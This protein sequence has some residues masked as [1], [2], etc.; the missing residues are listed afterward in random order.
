[1]RNK[2]IA[3]NAII[4]AIVGL[5]S[6]VLM[7]SAL[8]AAAS[9]TPQLLGD[10]KH[11]AQS[12]SARLQL[13]GLRVERWLTEK[14]AEPH[15]QDALNKAD[16]S[17][18][19]DAATALCD[20]IVAA[21]K[22]TPEFEGAVPSLVILV[23]PDGKILGRNNSTL[24]RKEDLG[25]AYPRFKE[26][27]AAGNSG[28]DVWVN[29]V[30]QDQYL[31]SYAPVRNDKGQI[32]GAI[33]AG[34][35][36]NDEL[37]RVADATTGRPM[38]IAGPSADGVQILAR[39]AANTG[40]LDTAVTGEGKTTVKS[41]LD[42][43]HSGASPVGDILIAAAP[44]EGFG[45]G[46]GSV[47]VV[48][49][50]ATIIENAGAIAM[51]LLGVTA[52]GIVLVLIGGWLLGNYIS[53]PIGELEEGL[54]AILNGQSDKRFNLDH[55]ELGGLAFRIDQ[56]LNQLMGVEEDTTDA[57]GRVSRTPSPAALGDDMSEEKRPAADPAAAQQLAAE[58]AA[59]YYA[60]LYREYVAAKKGIGEATDHITEQ[61]FT[62]RIQSMEQ[63]AQ[64]KQG[65]QVRYQV[66][67][68]G[69]EVILLPVPLG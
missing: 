2:I 67:A 54:L 24:L 58:P 43:N 39:S 65:R 46:K 13:D 37:S 44:L 26:A 8:V 7:R 34:F 25:A 53:G 50:P 20:S 42:T 11:N 22:T 63:E 10:A 14:A 28:S 23:G 64:Q 51:P 61:T 48:S 19:G 36:I 35:T 62:A 6:F 29:T 16:P 47:V 1:M 41:A 38:V 45:N 32:A 5:L 52:L 31:A 21:A 59:D 33:V 49:A 68:R 40:P 3:V 66:Q 55:A 56:L 15:T 60:R 17:A 69:N 18:G 9:P 27:V 12:A 57:E 30:R 4:I